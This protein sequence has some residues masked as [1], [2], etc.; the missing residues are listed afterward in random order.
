MFSNFTFS[1]IIACTIFSGS[2][3]F[4]LWH[5]YHNSLSIPLRF[6]MDEIPRLLNVTGLLPIYPPG[7]REEEKPPIDISP[8]REFELRLCIAKEWYRFPGHYVIPN[9]VRV[10]FVKSEFDGML[11]RHFEDEGRRTE[12]QGKSELDNKIG[13]LSNKWWLKPQTKLVPEDLN[14]KNQ[15]EPSHYVSSHTIA[16]V[17]CLTLLNRSLRLTVII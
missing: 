16:H 10:D 14:D 7:T 1:V 13:T 11:P 9:G 15:E 3:I 5:Y 17:S 8:I 6:Q 4:A 2:R 12:A